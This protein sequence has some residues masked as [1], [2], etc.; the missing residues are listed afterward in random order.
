[1]YSIQY[2]IKRYQTPSK[3]RMTVQIAQKLCVPIILTIM[4]L[5][6][7]WIFAVRLQGPCDE[8]EKETKQSIYM[9]LM[10]YE[11]RGKFKLFDPSH[12][13]Y[14]FVGY[15]AQRRGKYIS[16]M[17]SSVAHHGLRKREGGTSTFSSVKCLPAKSVAKEFLTHSTLCIAILF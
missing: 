2:T 14:N 9:G 3:N 10:P 4:F 1:M 16:S 7:R 17:H 12:D 5:H 8:Y 13:G 6:V 11:G 15:F